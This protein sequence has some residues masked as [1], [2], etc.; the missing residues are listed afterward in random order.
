MCLPLYDTVRG[1][2]KY[3][4]S[5]KCKK[6]FKQLK[7]YLASYTLTRGGRTIQLAQNIQEMGSANVSGR[8]KRGRCDPGDRNHYL[9]SF[10]ILLSRIQMLIF[11]LGFC[12][13]SYLLQTLSHL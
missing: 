6:T 8:G 9:M 5:K 12:K 2:K 3:E 13:A 4:L 10:F 1:N 7:H 11:Y